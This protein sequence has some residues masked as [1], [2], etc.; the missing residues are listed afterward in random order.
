M[1]GQLMLMITIYSKQCSVRSKCTFELSGIHH[2]RWIYL[3]CMNNEKHIE[4]VVVCNLFWS[5][6]DT[7]PSNL[8][9]SMFHEVFDRSGTSVFSDTQNFAGSPYSQ[10][11]K[12]GFEIRFETCLGYDS[13]SNAERCRPCAAHIEH[14]IMRLRGISVQNWDIPNWVS[15]WMNE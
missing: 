8:I 9:P 3:I 13:V 2:F 12:C 14:R 5:R 7:R 1:R 11:N 15:E 6:L 4:N 10:T